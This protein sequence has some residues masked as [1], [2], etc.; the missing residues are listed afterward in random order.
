MGNMSYCRF[1][2]TWGDLEECSEALQS[3]KD[4][5]DSETRCRDNLIDL[6]CDL[7]EEFGHIIGRDM[8]EE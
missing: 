6:C 7:A 2:N 8:V 3:G 4:L 5:S 1:E